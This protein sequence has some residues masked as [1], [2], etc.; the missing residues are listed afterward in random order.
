MRRTSQI[1]HRQLRHREHEQRP[2]RER[3]QP[4]AELVLGLAHPGV[5]EVHL[6]RHRAAV[7]EGQRDV[8]LDE[9]RVQGPL[10]D[11]LGA[12]E[13]MRSPRSHGPPSNTAASRSPSGKRR[14]MTAR[15]S[16][17]ATVPSRRKT[18]TRTS[19]P[20][21]RRTPPSSP[22]GRRRRCP[23]R[24]RPTSRAR[25]PL[26]PPPRGAQS[27]RQRVGAGNAT[28]DEQRRRAHHHE[29]ERGRQH[30]AGD[31]PL[32]GGEAGQR[33]TPG[34]QPKPRRRDQAA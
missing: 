33:R 1:D 9:V 23:R 25:V 26:G 18:L 19:V 15:S 13:S 16:D 31:N 34:P 12:G 2:Q 6:Q 30:Q 8:R 21:L 24:A 11:V 27:L 7:V 10:V 20:S 29:A 22:V 3:H 4:F 5:G 28:G 14:P 32:P 17:Q